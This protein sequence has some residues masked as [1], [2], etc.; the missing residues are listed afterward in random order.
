V[1]SHT[2]KEAAEILSDALSRPVKAWMVEHAIKQGRLQ[3]EKGSGG[4][5]AHLVPDEELHRL[6]AEI[7]EKRAREAQHE[8]T[9]GREGHAVDAWDHLP[10]NPMES[11]WIGDWKRWKR[12]SRPRQ[13]GPR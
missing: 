2:T 10:E 12:W 3:A 7:H 4:R 8:E 9:S 1:S 6:V 11:F 13:S 5:A